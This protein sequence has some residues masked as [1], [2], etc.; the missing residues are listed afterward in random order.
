MIG[1]AQDAGLPGSARAVASPAGA[2]LNRGKICHAGRQES[3]A[4]GAGIVPRSRP[5]RP[6][7]ELRE[8]GCQGCG[9]LPFGAAPTPKLIG[10]GDTGEI[11]FMAAAAPRI[12]S[13]GLGNS[14]G[15]V[16]VVA[17]GAGNGLAGRRQVLPNVLGVVKRPARAGATSRGEREVGVTLPQR[18]EPAGMARLASSIAQLT[19]GRAAA[20]M[21]DVT[22]GAGDGSTSRCS[23]AREETSQARLGS[24]SGPIGLSLG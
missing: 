5:M 6:M 11:A 24:T 22:T 17:G 4:G 16:Q 10:Y 15:L 2:C 13:S 8:P 9:A 7:G 12:R 19:Q 18:P 3:V 23:G 20:A 21:L 14:P 1:M